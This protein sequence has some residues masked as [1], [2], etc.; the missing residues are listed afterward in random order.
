[1]I[2]SYAKRTNQTPVLLRCDGC[3]DE[4]TIRWYSGLKWKTQTYCMTCAAKQ[5]WARRLIGHAGVA[6]TVGPPPDAIKQ[7]RGVG[8]GVL[9]QAR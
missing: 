5:T 1:M 4:Y 3:G 7:F 2:L 8:D 6:A 9:P